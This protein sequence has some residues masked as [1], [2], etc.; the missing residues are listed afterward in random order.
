MIYIYIYIYTYMHIHTYVCIHIHTHLSG[1]SWWLSGKESAA[2]QEIQE[3]QFQSLGQEVSLE[4]EMTTHSMILA[5]KMDRG[6][7]QSTVNGVAKSRD[8]TP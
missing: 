8:M 3:M 5:W 2:M 4:E 7:L 1:L 6:S